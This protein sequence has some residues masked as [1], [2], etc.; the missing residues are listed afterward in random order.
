MS[1]KIS[2][3][4]AIL[5][6]PVEHSLSPDIHNRV[7][8]ELSL[9]Y[10]YEK[11]SITP[12]EFIQ[13][14][15]LLKLSDW[16][17]F[18]VTVPFKSDIIS[19]LDKIDP[20]ADQIGAVNTIQIEKNGK[21]KGFNTDYLGFLR[22][23]P[24]EGTDIKS[25]LIIGAGGAARAVAFGII[26]T[27]QCTR[28]AIINR[29]Q[30]RAELIV[31]DLKKHSAVSMQTYSFDDKI[32]ETF[33]LI[34]NATTKGLKGIADSYPID[35]VPLAHAHTIVYDLIY[36]PTQFLKIAQSA[37]LKTINGWP[38]LVFQAEE[39]FKIW[40]GRNFSESV[41]KELLSKY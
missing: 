18:N 16:N 15:S 24:N 31:E 17:G 22:A 34:V 26:S 19:V 25:C 6:Y 28:L 21:W 14:I 1:N 41:R 27:T 8:E 33:D 36:K 23:L 40:T 3:R 12:G 2:K 38:M 32:T 29:S 10:S 37:G 35:P 20:I 39:A 11:I 9:P 13:K 7:F 30:N 4:F 5:G